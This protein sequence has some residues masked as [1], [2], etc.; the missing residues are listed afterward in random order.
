MTKVTKQIGSKKAI[1]PLKQ[2][3]CGPPPA[4]N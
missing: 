3:G 1:N 4:D 2:K